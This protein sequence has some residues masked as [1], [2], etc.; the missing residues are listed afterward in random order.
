MMVIAERASVLDYKLNWSKI[1]ETNSKESLT[2]C[3]SLQRLY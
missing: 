2:D 1:N 3:P